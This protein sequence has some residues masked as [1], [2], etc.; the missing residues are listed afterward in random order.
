A[1]RIYNGRYNINVLL[2]DVRIGD[3]VEFAYTVRSDE[4]LFPGHFATRLDTAWSMAMAKQ[5]I[6]VRAPVSRM[7]S[8]RMTDGTPLPEPRVQGDRS[9]LVME[10]TGVAPVAV[11]PGIPAWYYPWPSLEISDLE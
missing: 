10:W 7:L 8:Y 6:R 2:A 4:L 1:N 9:E 3:I 11:E 5:R